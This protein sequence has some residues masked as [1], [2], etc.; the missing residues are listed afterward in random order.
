LDGTY[1]EDS[2]AC[3]GEA[4]GWRDNQGDWIIY[5]QLAFD[6]DADAG[7]LP[8]IFVREIDGGEGQ[9]REQMAA[10]MTRIEACQQTQ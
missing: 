3:I 7:H 1:T 2:W 10:L 8:G 6:L 9:A 5:S 4:V